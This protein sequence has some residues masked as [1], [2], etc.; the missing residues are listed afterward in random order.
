[1]TAREQYALGPASGARIQKEGEQW[2]LVLT[3][4]LRHSRE[5]VW[6][7]LTDPT[8]LRE[9]APFEADRSLETAGASV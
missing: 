9:W 5:K 8:Q 1:M 4:D 3:R 2:T 7:A 6:Q